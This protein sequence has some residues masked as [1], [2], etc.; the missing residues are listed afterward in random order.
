[1]KTYNHLWYTTKSDG[2]EEGIHQEKSE[3]LFENLLLSFC[4]RFCVLQL[5]PF[6]L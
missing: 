6:F 1:M 3:T 2:I 4:S 5:H